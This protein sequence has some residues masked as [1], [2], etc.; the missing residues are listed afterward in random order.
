MLRMT[1]SANVLRTS[2]EKTGR[3]QRSRIDSRLGGCRDRDGSN[4]RRYG[5]RV[6]APKS[7]IFRLCR[8]CA[9]SA[10]AVMTPML[11]HLLSVV[12]TPRTGSSRHNRMNLTMALPNAT[13][14][15]KGRQIQQL[16][17]GA[18]TCRIYNP[19]F[20]AR[21]RRKCRVDQLK[22]TTSLG[23]LV[24]QHVPKH[25]PALVENGTIEARLGHNV[26]SRFLDRPL[27]AR[28][29]IPD[30]QFLD[31]DNAVALGDLGRELALIVLASVRSMQMQTADLGLE[32]SPVGRELR[33]AGAVL[34]QADPRCA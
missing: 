6:A 13:S 22:L 18:P 1:D 21:L 7:V 8:A 14:L 33:F 23:E 17:V 4:C 25:A 20:G 34:W 31:F 5:I 24:T 30:V 26:P 19:A 10:S 27:C 9:G 15:R 32:L 3:T 2:A 11:I 12:R 16:T 28:C 29:H